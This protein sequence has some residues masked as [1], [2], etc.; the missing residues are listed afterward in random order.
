MEAEA[1][2]TGSKDESVTLPYHRHASFLEGYRVA[3]VQLQVRMATRAEPVGECGDRYPI[4]NR[5][6]ER[7][8]CNPY[9][10]TMP[11][12]LSIE[13]ILIHAAS[14]LLRFRSTYTVCARV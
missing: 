4:K 8:Q 11:V 1:G 10:S 7:H 9:P 5:N 12:V 13:I 6:Y 2:R 3:L 14:P